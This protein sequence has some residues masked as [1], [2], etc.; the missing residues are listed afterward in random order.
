MP[1]YGSTFSSGSLP[2][3]FCQ[4]TVPVKFSGFLVG[5]L[6]AESQWRNPLRGLEGLGKV[7]QGVKSQG[8][9]DGS[10]GLG[11]V[12]QKHPRLLELGFFYKTVKRLPGSFFK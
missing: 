7:G 8:G 9:C 6:P 4:K 11:G 12:E 10:Q 2:F 1:W 3:G 5:P